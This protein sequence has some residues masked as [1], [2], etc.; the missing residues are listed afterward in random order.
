MTARLEERCKEKGLKMTGQRRVIAR[1]LSESTD[2]PDVETLFHRA[3]RF[4]PNI[5][6]ATIYRTV[7]LFE[8]VGV[9]ERHAFGD[10]KARY[11]ER[12]ES[13]HDHLIDMRSGA[14]V[15]F[16]NDVIER[17]QEAV[18]R[19]LGYRLVGHRLELYAVPLGK[20]EKI[21][22]VPAAKSAKKSKKA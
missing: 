11:E 9:L 17:M 2:H 18:A 13:H 20:A 1:V 14:V 10:G 8:E 16:K 15:E 21:K 4:D 5:S 3:A 6:I 7:H 12:P 22:L 19:K